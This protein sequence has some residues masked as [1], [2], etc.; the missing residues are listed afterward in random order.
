MV[1]ARLGTMVLGAAAAAADQMGGPAGAVAGSDAALLH[2]ECSTALVPAAAVGQPLPAWRP[3][4]TPPDLRHAVVLRCA[5]GHL[6]GR[7]GGGGGRGGQPPRERGQDHCCERRLLPA[8]CVCAPPC[9][10]T[11][12]RKHTSTGR[13]RGPRCAVRRVTAFSFLLP[14][15]AGHHPVVRRALPVLCPVPEPAGGGRG[16]DVRGV[17][18]SLTVLERRYPVPPPAQRCHARIPWRPPSGVLLCI[19]ECCVRSTQLTLCI[20]PIPLST[21]APRPCL[22]ARPTLLP[23]AMARLPLPASPTDLS[24]V[25][26][27][28]SSEPVNHGQQL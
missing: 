21:S 3:S 27:L 20:V 25:F 10:A 2:C 15:V 17:R 6:V 11:Q 16:S 26:L 24:M 22:P 19:S 8:V 12:A 1:S 23:D 14:H 28:N 4:L 9:N 5:G 13:S 7:R 18:A